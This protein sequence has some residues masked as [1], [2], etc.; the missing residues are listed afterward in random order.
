MEFEGVFSEAVGGEFFHVFG[1]V[2]DFDGLEGA[3][4]D[5]EAAADAE[6][7]WDVDDGG[8]GHDIDAD[9]FGLVDGTA[10]LALLFAALGFALFGVDDGDAVLVFHLL[11]YNQRFRLRQLSGIKVD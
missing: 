9:F 1:Y 2:D 3:L 6:Y 11:K 4:L 5:A 7:F 8:G 10:L